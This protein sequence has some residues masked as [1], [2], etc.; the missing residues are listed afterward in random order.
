VAKPVFEPV[1]LSSQWTASL[2]R[3]V[4]FSVEP[5]RRIGAIVGPRG[6]TD[7]QVSEAIRHIAANINT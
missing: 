2:Y 4:I 3:F 6:A 1:I 5:G 7:A